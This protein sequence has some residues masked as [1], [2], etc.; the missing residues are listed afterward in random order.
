[1]L[2]CYLLV[3]TPVRIPKTAYRTYVIMLKQH[4]LLLNHSILSISRV[5]HGQISGMHT[6]QHLYDVP[7]VK[8]GT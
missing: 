1:M 6:D 7:D 8:E 2:W 5:I 4:Q 3:K